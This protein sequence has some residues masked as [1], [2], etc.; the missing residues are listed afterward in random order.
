MEIPGN[1]PEPQDCAKQDDSASP[2]INCEEEKKAHPTVDLEP[3]PDSRSEVALEPDSGSDHGSESCSYIDSSDEAQHI[4]EVAMDLL[5]EE[6]IQEEERIQAE[7]A[8]IRKK[9][10]KTKAE[11]L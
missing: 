8:A 11:I 6:D 3:R 2:G 10:L 7:T 5:D 9:I 1:N 4:N